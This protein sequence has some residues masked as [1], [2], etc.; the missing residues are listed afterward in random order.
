M[1]QRYWGNMPIVGTTEE[2][3]QKAGEMARSNK[4]DPDQG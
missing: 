4:T 1:N 3:I 2:A